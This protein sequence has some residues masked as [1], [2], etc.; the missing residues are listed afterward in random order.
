MIIYIDSFNSI[1]YTGL[2]HTLFHTI[3]ICTGDE[4]YYLIYWSSEQK[5]EIKKHTIFQ[6]ENTL[7]KYF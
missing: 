4:F 7:R 3:W 6:K 1:V 2:S 5:I